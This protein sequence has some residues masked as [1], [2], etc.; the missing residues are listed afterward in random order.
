MNFLEAIR[1]Y[2]FFHSSDTEVALSGERQKRPLTVL[3]K[4]SHHLTA[5]HH[6]GLVVFENTRRSVQ[7]LQ[8]STFGL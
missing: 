4:L 8:I 2:L 3:D 6:L 7:T 1:A 5:L